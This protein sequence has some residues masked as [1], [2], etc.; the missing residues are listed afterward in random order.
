MKKVLFVIDS[1][2]CG[3]AERSLLSL[4]NTLDTKKYEK[5][6]WILHPG[7][8]LDK[9]VPSDV[10]IVQS[11]LYSKIHQ[12]IM[13]LCQG[14][15]SFRLRQNGKKTHQSHPAEL[16]WKSFG[17]FTKG[18]ED[19]YDVAVAYQ[20]G[21]PTYLVAT[22][23]HADIKVGW[24]NTDIMSAGYDIRYNA[25][26]YEKMSYISCVSDMLEEKVKGY[27]PQFA[28]KI[29]CVYDIVSPEMVRK[30]SSEVVP[31]LKDLP[32]G[33][34]VLT[35]V[36]RMAY[37]KNYPLAVQTASLLRERG[38][39]FIWFFVGQGSMLGSIRQM[40]VENNLEDRV[41]ALG[42]R[43][44]PYPYINGCDIYVQTSLHEG[45]G[46]TISEAKM[47][48]KP[49][50]S[51]DFDVVYNQLED[52][53]NGLITKKTPESLADA[54]CRLVEDKNLRQQFSTVLKNSVADNADTEI[55]KVEELFGL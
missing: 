45:F 2:N 6:L 37:L 8:V 43:L 29:R 13:R 15:F 35:T 19:S 7:G 40:I 3:G 38:V 54:I 27:M 53:V 10:T 55:R 30:M 21:T 24:I 16:Y 23:I 34:I 28:S 52:G 41:R 49:I 26:F 48:C 32:S 36:A 17:F 39:D 12:W 14:L 42:L 22:K 47:L 51:T 5:H 11:P 25:P 4:L 9:V 1:L 33:R 20:Q 46:L 18:L 31:E 50:V 44:N